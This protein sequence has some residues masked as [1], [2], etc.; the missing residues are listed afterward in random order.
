MPLI[1]PMNV[2]FSLCFKNNYQYKTPS[3]ILP[4]FL[5]YN[6]YALNTVHFLVGDFSSGD[7]MLAWGLTG[8]QVEVYQFS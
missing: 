1:F 3:N 4:V 5:K 2:Y 8:I 7:V 6:V